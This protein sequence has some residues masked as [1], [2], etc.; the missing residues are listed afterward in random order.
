MGTINSLRDGLTNM[1]LG[2][3]SIPK[4]DREDDICNEIIYSRQQKILCN[5]WGETVV[6]RTNTIM[7][8]ESSLLECLGNAEP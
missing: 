4:R 5:I 7:R 2:N 8:H 6:L 3:N 1:N